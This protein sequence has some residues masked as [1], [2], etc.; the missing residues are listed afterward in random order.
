MRSLLLPLLS[1]AVVVVAAAPFKPINTDCMTW[2]KITGGSPHKPGYEPSRDGPPL[3]V[4]HQHPVNSFASMSQQMI[5]ASEQGVIGHYDWAGPHQPRGAASSPKCH[6]G[7]GQHLSPPWWLATFASENLTWSTYNAGDPAPTNAYEIGGLYLARSMAESKGPLRGN[8]LPGW[9]RVDA[10]SHGMLSPCSYEDFGG[11]NADRF[12]LATCH[13]PTR[14]RYRCDNTTTTTAHC[15]TINATTNSTC[16]DKDQGCGPAIAGGLLNCTT[17]LC[18]SCPK[19]GLCDKSCKFCSG[20]GANISGSF[21]TRERVVCLLASTPDG[22]CV[23]WGA[24]RQLS[25]M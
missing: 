9:V 25:D 15:V 11:H 18:P 12:E 16:R 13:P 4:G 6:T 17:D 10:E 14:D 2:V 23:A 19:K 22:S 7:N 24:R 5:C 1:T 20:A 21:Q 3:V 8:V